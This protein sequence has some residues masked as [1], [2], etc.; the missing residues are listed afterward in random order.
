MEYKVVN[1]KTGRRALIDDFPTKK[2]AEQAIVNTMLGAALD[3]DKK[4][5]LKYYQELTVRTV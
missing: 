4:R 2:A 3:K 1:K 5:A